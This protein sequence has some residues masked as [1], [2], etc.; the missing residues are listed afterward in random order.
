MAEK[1]KKK[2]LSALELSA[3]SIEMANMLKVGISA[4]EAITLMEEEATSEEERNILKGMKEHLE[5]NGS[6]SQAIRESGLFPEYYQ[7]MVELGEQTGRSDQV[8]SDLEAYYGREASMKK[9]VRNAVSY[10]LLMVVMMVVVIVVLITKVMPL[11]E[12]VFTQLG[13]QMSGI[14]GGL[15]ALGNILRNYSVAFVIILL[16]L[17]GAAVCIARHDKGK[18][19]IMKLGYKWKGIRKIY[20]RIAAS[21]FANGMS[22]ALKSGM[23]TRQALEMTAELVNN[24]FFKEKIETCMGMVQEYVLLSKAI[25]D[26]NMF[27]GV[28][29]RMIRI[30]E[31]TGNLEEVLERIAVAYRT[32]ADEEIDNIISMVEPTLVILLSIMV[33]IILLSVMLPLLGIMSGIN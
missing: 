23:N 17:V 33:G 14:S 4:L 29:G 1:N 7:Q 10:P 25:A 19:W 5:L 2:M 22:I 6:L 28:Y 20:E 13:S 31:K 16:V 12:R 11:F 27:T 30:S 18:L 8:M 26:T 9:A 21:R 3:F 32:E 24:P 15:L